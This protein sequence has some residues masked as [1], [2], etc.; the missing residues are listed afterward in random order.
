MDST[1]SISYLIFLFYFLGSER[2]DIG[3][4]NNPPFSYIVT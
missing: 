4:G 1:A 3:K 2:L